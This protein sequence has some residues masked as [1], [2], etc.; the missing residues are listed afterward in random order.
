MTHE[1]KQKA[2]ARAVAVVILLT[3]ELT[4]PSRRVVGFT[5]ENGVVISQALRD[6]A[7]AIA[8]LF[9]DVRQAEKDGVL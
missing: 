2:A 9:G 6:E 4:D 3:D 5:R 8:K 7:F 1:E